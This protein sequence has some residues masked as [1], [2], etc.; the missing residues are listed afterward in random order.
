MVSYG[1]KSVRIMI[2]VG[3]ACARDLAKLLTG[4][5]DGGLNICSSPIACTARPFELLSSLGQKLIDGALLDGR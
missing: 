2:M 1:A 3:L 5:R 4:T